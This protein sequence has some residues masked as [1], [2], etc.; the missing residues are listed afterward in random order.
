MKTKE[1][2][3]KQKPIF[4]H[5]WAKDK[6]FAVIADFEDICLS[7]DEYKSKESPW[8]NESFWI[9]QKAL[10]DKAIKKYENI[11][12][13]F[14]S[15]DIDGYEGDAFVIFEQD[16]ELYEVNAG[17]CSCYGLEGQWIPEP[18]VLKEME[19]RI[20]NGVFGY[21]FFKD[22]LKTFLGLEI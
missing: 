12:I 11:N 17:H 18:V 8:V 22:D 14:A 15:Y 10:M 19:N 20:E 9:E 13:L 5:N 6:K 21:N 7:E 4:L 16:N 3:I 2:I 1:E